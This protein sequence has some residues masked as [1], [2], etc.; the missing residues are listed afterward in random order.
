MT[1]ITPKQ[2]EQLYG[3]ES[4]GMFADLKKQKGFLSRVGSSIKDS[5]VKGKEQVQGTGEFEDSIAPVRGVQL[6]GTMATAIPKAVMSGVIPNSAQEWLGE[7]I[8]EPVGQG[9]KT[10]TDLIG[11]SQSLQKFVMNNPEA[12]KIIEET[13]KVTGALSEAA[14]GLVA[15]KGMVQSVSSLASSAQKGVGAISNVPNLALPGGEQVKSA[16]SNLFKNTKETAKVVRDVVRPVIQ[17]A[18][19]LPGKM[20]A[21]VAQTRATEATINTLKPAG[22]TAVRSGVE[23]ADVK[24]LYNIPKTISPKL[25]PLVNAVQKFASGKSGTNPIE[26]VGKPIMGAFKKAQS[27]ASS[28]GV[29]LGKVADGLGIV[30]TKQTFPKVF[31][32]LKK[33]SGLNGLKVNSKGIL[34]FSNTNLASALS[35]S[36]RVAIQK[37]FKDAIKTGTGKSKHLYRQE[38]FNILGGKKT[39]LAGLSGTQ[40]NAFNAIRKGLSD[41]LDD[42]N[43]SYKT[44]NTQFAKA[45]SPIQQLKK[46]L[47][48]AGMDDDLAN[49]KAGLLARRLTSFSKSNPEIRQILRDLDKV[50]G[51]S[52]KTALGV[53]KLQDFY[54][55]LDKYYDIAGQTGFQG[56]VTSGVSKAIGGKGGVSKAIDVVEGQITKVFGE[57]D[58]VKQRALE[59]ILKEILGN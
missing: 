26:I 47:K 54:N 19:T 34:D 25:K 17:E 10:V 55:I 5:F 53:E 32:Q 33:V 36:D 23:L 57:T 48:T 11:S 49:M 59:A 6:A 29:K 30:T 40:E 46:M 4:L 56:Q 31:G 14:G 45:M 24:T 28:I 41:V 2:F 37:I 20:R 8:A 7:N 16:V 58:I 21:N 22:Q 35:K 27:K 15:T 44:L 43:P 13:A 42:L 18:K 1:T 12:T 9:F 50:I 51:S 38:L 39:G 3:S 52:S